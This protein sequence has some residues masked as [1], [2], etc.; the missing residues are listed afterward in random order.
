MATF[1]TGA[2]GFIGRYL[3]GAM[4]EDGEDL[5]LLARGRDT[6]DSF[7][8]VHRAIAFSCDMDP[9]GVASRATIC[10]GDLESPGL[11]L[12]PDDRERIIAT[13]NRYL[14]CG[15][16]VRFDLPLEKARAINVGG[17]AKI[18]D[19]ARERSRRYQLERVDILST[20]YV[21]GL[22]TDLVS[23]TELDGRAGH[24]NTY[25]RSKF[26]AERLIWSAK[27]E[28]PISVFRPSAVVGESRT[29]RTSSFLT[30]YLPIKMYARGIWRTLPGNPES[31]IDLVPVDFVRDAILGIRRSP[32]NVGRCFHIA[33][34]PDG[35]ATL[36]ELASIVERFFPNR[37]RIRF[38]D[39]L[40][41]Q[42]YALP[43][44]ELFGFGRFAEVANAARALLPYGIA[45]P[46]FDNANTRMALAGS[47]IVLPHVT[48]YIE[49]LLAYGVETDWG[50]KMHSPKDNHGARADFSGLEDA[51][52]CSPT[53]SPC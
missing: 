5:V 27:A 11:G 10:V 31:K 36:G 12:R 51:S 35:E 23:E 32:D 18:L 46:S 52:S 53:T 1:L 40:R 14:H 29:G 7:E 28:L 2:T 33:A 15:A 50:R 9:S 45:N 39:P 3:A 42:R 16:S 43:F 20:A 24:K 6:R 41:W 21:A 37:K 13:C 17:T 30:I 19:L 34:G 47:G 49:R 44:L 38:A 26:E 8:R 4:I 48:A 22:R 25:E